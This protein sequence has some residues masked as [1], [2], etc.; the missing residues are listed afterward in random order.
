MIYDSGVRRLPV[1]MSDYRGAGGNAIAMTNRAVL[2]RQARAWGPSALLGLLLL[3]NHST[4]SCTRIGFY[5]AF[6][7]CGSERSGWNRRVLSIK[8]QIL[9]LTRAG[10]NYSMC[11]RREWEKKFPIRA[12]AE[13]PSPTEAALAFALRITSL[14]P[15]VS[16]GQHH[17]EINI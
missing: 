8:G 1:E 9:S 13:L 17:C 11:S 12:C 4:A 10:K 3:S 7:D 16:P 2:E 5:F 15:E 6:P 14:A